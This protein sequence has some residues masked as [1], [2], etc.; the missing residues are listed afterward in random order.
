MK[1]MKSNVSRFIPVVMPLLFSLNL[2]SQIG[3]HSTFPF[4]ERDYQ[5]IDTNAQSMAEGAKMISYYLKK[6]DFE[7]NEKPPDAVKVLF[8]D[9]ICAEYI[10]NYNENYGYVVRNYLDGSV[11]FTNIQFENRRILTYYYENGKIHSVL[12]YKENPND[13]NMFKDGWQFEF[14]ESGILIN[15]EFYVEGELIER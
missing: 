10:V 13:P 6:S 2:A 7:S 15:E 8:N 4:I 14:N 11:S 5:Y 3:M 1:D 12:N 9:S